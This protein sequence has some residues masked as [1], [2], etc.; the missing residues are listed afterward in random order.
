MGKGKLPQLD[1]AFT[2]SGSGANF[3]AGAV[4]NGEKGWLK[5]QGTTYVVD[6]ATFAQ[7]KQGYEQ[8]A[9]KTAVTTAPRPR[10]SSPWASTRCAG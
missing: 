8:S 7:F 5:L 10:A 4:T 1:L 2:L 3:A 6:D 9:S